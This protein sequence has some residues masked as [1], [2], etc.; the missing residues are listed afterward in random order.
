MRGSVRP[1]A[2][3]FL[4]A[5]LAACSASAPDGSRAPALILPGLAAQQASLHRLRVVGGDN[6]T[7]VTLE[8]DRGLWRVRE[9]VDWPADPLLVNDVITTLAQVRGSEAKT[10][11]PALYARIGV[12]PVALPASRSTELQLEG[13][14]G[15]FAVLIGRLRLNPRGSYLRV[16]ADKQSWFGD[17]VLDVP[18]DPSEWLDHGLVDLPLAR[19]AAVDIAPADSP[20]FRLVRA[21]DRFRVDDVAPV[22]AK[23]SRQADALAGV[24]NQ[25]RFE[26]VARDVDA[27]VPERELKFLGIDGL[28]I[29][30]QCWRREGR[31]WVRMNA[32]VDEARAA[33]W[34]A[35]TARSGGDAD[36]AGL[37]ARV[38][39]MQARWSGY[40]FRLPALEASVLMQGRG[41]LLADAP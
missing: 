34:F 6:Q 21:D 10:D 31:I 37:H 12:E 36:I 2:L 8:K 13:D 18:R 20:A 39:A 35:Q 38:T 3:C 14:G 28:A 11:D 25:L 33:A 17:R 32:S 15:K 29:S 27:P 16:S 22:A 24:L 7:L 5:M 26:D 19:V 4:A 9:R 40:V 41:Q 23:G 30:M 1:A